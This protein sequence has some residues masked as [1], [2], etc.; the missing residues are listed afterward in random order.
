M[1]WRA[2]RTAS[3]IDRVPDVR[4]TCPELRTPGRSACLRPAS[5]GR[6]RPASHLRPHPANRL[7]AAAERALGQATSS[8]APL[9][10]ARCPRRHADGPVAPGSEPARR[11]ADQGRRATTRPRRARSEPSADS[12]GFVSSAG[13][14]EGVDAGSRTRSGSPAPIRPAGRA[15]RARERRRAR[16]EAGTCS[17][18]SVTVGRP[19]RHRR[20]TSGARQATQWAAATPAVVRVAPGVPRLPCGNAHVRRRS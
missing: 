16:G 3:R 14:G 1:P 18:R 7:A 5:P 20:R 15:R 13:E 19:T 8:P 17:I 6:P 4:A 2:A 9:R 10:P 11:R 12:V